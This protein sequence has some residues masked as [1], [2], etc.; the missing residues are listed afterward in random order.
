MNRNRRDR[1][2]QSLRST[3]PRCGARRANARRSDHSMARKTFA[4]VVV[5]AMLVD[6]LLSAHRLAFV[7]AAARFL[8]VRFSHDLAAL[9]GGSTA[10]GEAAH[11]NEPIAA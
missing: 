10:P 7:R 5:E 1:L 6:P 3:W 4:S 2:S 11:E 8:R 9:R